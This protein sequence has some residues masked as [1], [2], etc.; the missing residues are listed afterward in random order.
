MFARIRHWLLP[1]HTNNFRA[2]LLHNSGLIALI[3]IMLTFN[4]LLR[5]VERLPSHILGFTSS[6]SI[7]EVVRLTNQERV[8][9]GLEPLRYSEVLADAA[10]RKAANMFEENYWA[11]NSPSG[12]TPWEWFKAAGYRY[13]HAGENLA[14]DFGSTDRLMQA[15]MDSPTHRA[16]IVSDKYKDIGIAVVPGTLQGHETVLVV[17]LFGTTVGTGT[18]TAQTP[19]TTPAVAEVR[20]AVI[21]QTTPAPVMELKEFVAEKPAPLITL[22]EFNLKKYASLAT[23]VLLMFVLFA[24]LF[25]AESNKLSRRV[26]KNWAHL[27]FINVILIL[28]TIVNSGIII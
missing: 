1:H 23:T 6:V 18:V 13:A 26:G 19:Q 11:H 21:P 3:G 25:I 9:Q 4:L 5:L 12:K 7:E 10:R 28:V 22:N 24:D 17:Q 8:A 14:K 20:G 16:N 15:W 27:V 2:K